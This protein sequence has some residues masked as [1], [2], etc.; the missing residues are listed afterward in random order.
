M[1]NDSFVQVAPDSTGKKIDNSQ[2]TTGSGT[3]QRQR[4]VLGD[5]EGRLATVTHDGL[6]NTRDHSSDIFGDLVAQARE[7]QIEV[8]FDGAA[9]STLVTVTTTSTGTATRV[10]GHALFSTGTGTTSSSKGVS[11]TNV[12]YKAGHE[13]YVEFTAAFTAPIASSY[14]RIGLYD[15]TDGF[16]VS[17]ENTT[18]GLT[19]RFNTTDTRVARASWNGDP[20]DGSAGSKFMRSGTPEAINLAFSNLYRV[21]FGWLGS[22]PIVFEVMSPDGTWVTFHTIRVPNSQLNPSLTNPDLP[23]TVDVSKT[24]AGATDLVV[25]TAC[26]AAGTTSNL[27]SLATTLSDRSLAQLVRAVL[28]GKTTA[29][30]GA[31][32]AVKVNPS[33]T[34]TVDASGSTGLGVTHAFLTNQTGTWGY[35]SGSLTGAGNV[36]GSGKCV[37]IRVFANGADSSFNINGGNTISVRSNSGVDIDPKG[38]VTAPVVN[39]VSGSID[40]IIEGLA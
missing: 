14:Q 34:L 11:L 25:Y 5:D 6:L 21:R 16:F 36:T 12:A 4:I 20:L 26:W 13:I 39:W 40:V 3:V 28:V 27:A 23:I 9:P 8:Q 33:G 38:T 29:G 7:N 32:V 15:A 2:V 17:Y 24:A 18:F 35:V 1:A 10:T 37:G 31:Y 22:A 30:G 19:W